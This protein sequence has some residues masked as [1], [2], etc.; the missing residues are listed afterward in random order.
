MRAFM[1]GTTFYCNSQKHET[2]FE[3][4]EERGKKR[5]T[6]S[7]LLPQ[8]YRG[9]QTT[10]FY[11]TIWS[12]TNRLRQKTALKNV[13]KKVL[14]DILKLMIITHIYIL[15]PTCS[16][17]RKRG[18]SQTWHMENNTGGT[19]GGEILVKQV[20]VHFADQSFHDRCA[21]GPCRDT[22]ATY[23]LS[24]WCLFKED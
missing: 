24:Y 13:D 12:N 21:L 9:A 11:A 10:Q 20:A 7:H 3:P 17:L 4:Q 16:K 23:S 5:N 22:L 15:T 8:E 14:L 6:P 18:G 19:N 2:V 1:C